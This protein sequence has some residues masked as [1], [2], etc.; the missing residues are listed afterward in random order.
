VRWWTGGP[1]VMRPIVAEMPAA[2]PDV[3]MVFSN[4]AL[5]VLKPM[6]GNMPVVFVGVGDPVGRLRCE[7]RSSWRQH[8]RLRRH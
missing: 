2:S 6:A 4:L 1:D 8:H 5:A 3:I 7:P